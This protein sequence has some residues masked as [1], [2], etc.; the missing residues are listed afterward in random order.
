VPKRV[1]FSRTQSII[2]IE[3][4][5]YQHLGLALNRD[6]GDL[7]INESYFGFL[8]KEADTLIVPDINLV[9]LSQSLNQTRQQPL[10]SQRVSARNEIIKIK[11]QMT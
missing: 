3:I 1:E 7:R 10:R 6:L 8:K 4:Y 5:E 11:N 9:P 2:N